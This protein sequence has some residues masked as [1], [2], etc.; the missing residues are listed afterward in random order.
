MENTNTANNNLPR[1]NQ[2]FVKGWSW[3]DIQV[4]ENEIKFECSNQP[5]FTIPHSSIA[6]VVLPTKNEIG[7]EF[8]LDEEGDDTDDYLCEMRLYIPNQ[9]S[10]ALDLEEDNKSVHSGISD[11]S[12]KKSDRSGSQKEKTNTKNTAESIK[13]EISKLANIGSLGEAIA[14]VSEIPMLTPRGKFDVYM[15]KNAIKIHG[16][17]HDYKISHKNISQ[18]FVLPKP[19]G[20]HVAFVVGLANALRQGNTSYPFLVFQFKND[21]K[22]TVEVNI[23]EDEKERKAILK[24]DIASELSGVLFDI[25]AKLFQALVGVRVTMPGSFRSSKGS[26]AI[27][28]SVKANEGYLYPLERC[29]IFIHKPVILIQLEDIRHVE[30]VRI[31]EGSHQKSFDLTVMTKKEE[32]QFLGIEKN[33]LDSLAGYFSNKRVK[34]KSNEGNVMAMKTSSVSIF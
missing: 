20:V 34:V 4:L 26:I 12:N 16:A 31:Q 25:M 3:G 14:I 18:V 8:N 23:P 10:D 11:D 17:S 6:N 28:C 21:L 30:C 33:E 5:W 27:K 9:N 15:L 22:R 2:Q 7:L 29:L 19:D 1:S 24:T 32:I 13:D